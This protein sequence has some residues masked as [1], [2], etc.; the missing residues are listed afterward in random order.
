[1]TGPVSAMTSCRNLRP[2][3]R[4]HIGDIALDILDR[5]VFIDAMGLEEA[6]QL[7]ATQAEHAPELRLRYAPSPE[8]FERAGFKRPA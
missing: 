7:N 8:F 6:I 3:A 2:Q 1:L 4:S 5:H